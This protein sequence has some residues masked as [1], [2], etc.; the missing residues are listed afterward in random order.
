MHRQ[1]SDDTRPMSR[2]L[3]CDEQLAE[4]DPAT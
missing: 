1:T 2:P 4:I 3:T